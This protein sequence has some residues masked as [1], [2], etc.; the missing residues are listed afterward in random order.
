MTLAP[1]HLAI[2]RFLDPMLV[3]LV[4]LAAA[5]AV[6][7]RG[8]VLRDR[9]ARVARVV[10]WCA[11]G[12][13]WVMS[14]PAVAGWLVYWAESRGPALDVALAGRDPER[15]ALV[16]LA[17]GMRSHDPSVLPRE[18]LDAPTTQR[19]LTA[20]RLWKEH[21]FGLVVLSGSPPPQTVCMEDLITTLGVPAERVVREPRSDNTRENAAFTADILRARGIETVVMVTSATHLRRAV[22]AFERAGVHVIP[23]AADVAGP[24]RI[25]LDSLLPSSWSMS[26]TH[27]VLHEVLGRLRP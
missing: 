8:A 26:R 24:N 10:A 14:T 19:V 22:E 15:S 4:V 25:G 23:A 13:T 11:W 18:R 1:S 16:V 3:M 9:R 17:A 5:L 12:S 21:R 6:A 7:F 27:V 20:A 2:S